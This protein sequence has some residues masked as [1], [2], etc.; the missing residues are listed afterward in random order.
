MSGKSKGFGF[1]EMA[2]DEGAESAI[3]MFDGAE[4]DGRKVRV[5]EARP[6]EDRPGGGGDRGDRPQR[7]FQ[8][9]LLTTLNPCTKCTGFWYTTSMIINDDFVFRSEARMSDFRPVSMKSAVFLCSHSVP[10]PFI[11]LKPIGN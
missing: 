4:L 2:T 6:K 1:V 5:N 3:S 7:K 11:D 9:Q 8:K 10:T